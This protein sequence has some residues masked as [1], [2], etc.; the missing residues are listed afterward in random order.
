MRYHLFVFVLTAVCCSF[1][2]RAQEAE[3][4]GTVT[5]P[6]GDTLIGAS[7]R[8]VGSVIGATTNLEG[9]YQLEVP[10][11]RIRLL[12]TYLGFENFDTVL[13]VS[14]T[15]RE[16]EVDIEMRESFMTTGE[17]IVYGRRASGQAQA[18]RVQQSAT[19]PQTIIHS[20]LFNKYPDITLAE[21]V[22]RMPG[23]TI[24]RNRGEGEL[25][26]VRGL[27]EQY[28]AI[29]LNGQRLPAVQPEA[30]RAGSLDIIQSNLVEEVRVIKARSADMDADA[31]GGTVDFRIRQP[32]ERAEVLLQAGGGSNFGFD[33]IPGQSSSITQAT[34]VL[35]SELSDEAVYGLL[36]GSYFR[37][38]RGNRTQ[39]FDYGQNGTTGRE[40]SRVRPIDTDRMT[41][42]LG[43]IGAVELRPS[44][45]N[46][47]R[48]SYN[49]S[50]ND[51]VVMTREANFNRGGG[52]GFL[53][54]RISSRW[55]EERRLNMVALEV[56]NNFK[57]TQ[58]TYALSFAS[59]SERVKD[60][61]RA[62]N[63][64]TFGDFRQYSD[65]EFRG[66]LPTDT[67]FPNDQI[68][69]RF[70]EQLNLDLEEDIAIGGVNLTRFLSS[71]RSSF[72]RAG[73]RYRIKERTYQEFYAGV[74][75][76]GSSIPSTDFPD[77][78]TEP[79]LNERPDLS[80]GPNYYA[81]ERI[82]A[83][84][85]MFLANWTAKLTTS[86][87]L[88]YEYTDL[89]YTLQR[90]QQTD[91]TNYNDLFPS[92]NI[93]YR[94]KRD[95]QLRFSY[96]DAI[97]RV[98]YATVV[99]V[100]AFAERRQARLDVFS[101]D[102]PEVR[103]T[104][105]RNLDLTYERYGRYDGLISV[106]AYAKFLTDP[107]V[108]EAE[109][110]FVSDQPSLGYS[111]AN[112]ADARLLGLEL[113][114][115]QS[116]AF[117]S[118]KLRILNVNGN[119][120]LNSYTLDGDNSEDNTL[121][122]APRRSANLSLIYSNPR[123]RLNLVVAGNYRSSTLDL[124]QDGQPVWINA[125]ISLDLAVDYELFKGI[126]AYLR[127]NNATD[128]RAERYIGKPDQDDSLLLSKTQY[129]IWGVAGLRWRPGSN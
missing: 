35:N 25:V 34:A 8:V 47:M 80:A 41:T 58:L 95:H 61:Q 19:V 49:Y 88:R 13:V 36:G 104:Y 14:T 127:L 11:G 110:A 86:V 1:T 108:R 83:G 109:F 107:T 100:Q 37:H 23:V 57:Q 117:L 85:L 16:L 28:T 63:S 120:N 22:Q 97:A 68:A 21:T 30:D 125:V 20:E 78:S 82:A 128:H 124:L 44:I 15:D 96:Y 4:S 101:L 5:G 102:N 54:D 32:E 81:S 56:E 9:H 121:A 66:L 7:V 74:P 33:Q 26:Q 52:T 113:G 40:I 27:P 51:E 24:T 94:L 70:T 12:A 75:G 112:T 123:T 114:F 60:R 129:G 79:L 6:G 99:P 3:I 90:S 53:E 87:G 98:P 77:L 116:L 64:L 17:V 92:L 105:S 62:F 126:S 45:Y 89:D 93:T 71:N 111:L 106:S 42:K 39:R 84:Y 118:P 115:Y 69:R 38:N 59:T 91:S 48:L 72:I 50:A 103:P 55:R 10:P 65:E 119:V 76:G 73:G 18:L 46:R 31:I 29:S 67:Q 2:L 43:L 122:Q